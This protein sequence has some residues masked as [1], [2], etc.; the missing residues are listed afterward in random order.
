MYLLFVFIHFRQ[1]LGAV[2]QHGGHR[3][4]HN[5]QRA[6]EVR[7]GCAAY[8]HPAAAERRGQFG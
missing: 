3:R 6:K 2:R 5:G 4:L 8:C 1:R 7:S